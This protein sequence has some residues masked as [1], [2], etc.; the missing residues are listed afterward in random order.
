MQ[1]SLR[2]RGRRTDSSW[3]QGRGEVGAGTT[4]TTTKVYVRDSWCD[5][6]QEACQ[7][8]ARSA[9]CQEVAAVRSLRAL[10]KKKLKC[11][12]KSEFDGIL[13]VIVIKKIF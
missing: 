6:R 8:L 10:R 12:S 7:G 11:I 13:K 5:G 2:C 9:R 4:S 1:S 3:G